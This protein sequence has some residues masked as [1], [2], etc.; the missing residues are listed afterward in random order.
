MVAIYEEEK[1]ARF[2][3][4]GTLIGD[5]VV[6]TAAHCLKDLR[7]PLSVVVG[8]LR[9]DGGTNAGRLMVEATVP[10]PA[11]RSSGEGHDI[12]LLFL[13]KSEVAARSDSASPLP[14]NEDASFPGTSPTPFVTAMGW[15]N[16]TSYGHLSTGLLQ[17]VRLP[18]VPLT[19]CRSAGDRYRRIPEASIC[20]GDM[21]QGG[22][23]ACQGDSGGPLISDDQSGQ[24]IL[25]GIASWGEGCAQPGKPGVYTRVA[26]YTEWLKSEIARF[27]ESAS[28]EN[29]AE[30]Q[31][32]VN[33]YCFNRLPGRESLRESN[34]SYVHIG[35]FEVSE[36]FTRT[37]LSI[38]ND[39]TPAAECRFRIAG[40]GLAESRIYRSEEGVYKAILTL[41]DSH[42]VWLAPAA[43]TGRASFSC[44][45]ADRSLTL[46]RA[47]YETTAEL[48]LDAETFT[49]RPISG[50]LPDAA[51]LV[52]SCSLGE[53][54]LLLYR[55][56]AP[57][58]PEAPDYMVISGI[59]TILPAGTYQLLP[60]QPVVTKRATLRLS[61]RSDTWG[62]ATLINTSG[63]VIYSW[64]VI[65]QDSL[66]VFPRGTI[67]EN[68]NL[69]GDHPG[70]LE[71]FH[72]QSE[73][74][75]I[76][77]NA[78]IPIDYQTTPQ[79]AD[80][81]L[82]TCRLNGVPLAIEIASAP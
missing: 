1:I 78:E 29:G 75:R 22:I 36:P 65:C 55:T 81:R 7:K 61:P 68:G 11:Y 13:P 33:S 77:L 43:L 15:G 12:A 53:R 71:L 5:G 48:S 45:A 31:H 32:L 74:G 25:L 76:A 18:I 79:H 50:S 72:P 37:S 24:P 70:F 6:V 3:C 2:V 63:R 47:S 20:A 39:D 52:S 40:R 44:P 23:D 46:T 26:F 38:D 58:A 57:D 64:N 66:R 80:L 10:H 69:H 51:S 56:S 67:D 16:Q 28:T 9:A 17:E 42:D 73:Y 19:I 4:G 21:D 62:H 14:M 59:D 60:Q 30:L 8:H 35:R 49:T 34:T 82:S 54:R 41:E 27:R